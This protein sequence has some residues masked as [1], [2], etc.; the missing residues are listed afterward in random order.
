MSLSSKLLEIL[1]CP[2][3]KSR[4]AQVEGGRG[5]LC[6]HCLLKFPVREGIPVMLVEEASDMRGAGV[7]QK[8]A[9]APVSV[10]Q[11][12]T[13]PQTRT[14]PQAAKG[15][16]QQAFGKNVIFRVV[17]GPDESMTFDLKS[18]TCRAI[19]RSSQDTTKTT[20]LN[21]DW[22]LSLDEETKSLVLQYISQQFRKPQAT[23]EAAHADQLGAFKRAPDVVLKDQT[24]SRLHAMIFFDDIGIG[25]LDLVS[26]N[27]TFVNAEEIESRLLKKGDTI[28]LGET[29]IIFEG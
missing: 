20:V 27:G 10:P 21:V 23:Q 1:V 19:G 4:L 2:Q 28:E 11:A 9:A 25:I 3:C 17:Q 26:K 16:P 6:H 8:T 22:A 12:R 29:K 15:A 5:L 18:G 13:A 14:T 24:L 7:P